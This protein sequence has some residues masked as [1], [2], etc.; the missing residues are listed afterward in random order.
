MPTACNHNPYL[1]RLFKGISHHKPRPQII[2]DAMSRA[3]RYYREPAN[4]LPTLQFINS[5]TT[6]QRSERREGILATLQLLLYYMHL[7]NQEV[8]TG[9]RKDGQMNYLSIAFIAKR[10]GFGY[11][12]VYR[13]L[14]DLKN[15]AYIE[16]ERK[17]VGVKKVGI[18]S[19]MAIRINKQ[20]FY[21]LGISHARLERSIH[22]KRKSL[23]KK[24]PK[25]TDQQRSKGLFFTKKLSK[26]INVMKE[27]TSLNNFNVVAA[28]EKEKPVKRTLN[29]S[30]PSP[31]GALSPD[32]RR[33]RYQ[34]IDYLMHNKGL[35]LDQAVAALKI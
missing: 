7:N 31:L 21:A 1:P 30:P 25:M 18:R 16:V 4:Y 6:R 2:Q 27:A 35:T 11:K 32:E 9:Y 13:A 3:I 5:S 17:L 29:N 14:C 8:G 22:F 33:Q 34:Q 26:M 28:P 23:E 24:V 15:A 20:L 19:L 10:L 12:R